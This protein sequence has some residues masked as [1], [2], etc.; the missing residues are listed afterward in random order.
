MALDLE[1][2]RVVRD[3]ADDLVAAGEAELAME[4]PGVVEAEDM[5]GLLGVEPKLGV[6]LEDRSEVGDEIRR[7]LEEE[8]L[9]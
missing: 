6:T 7:G 3:R 1:Q 8:D 2:E 9:R 4:L 5:L